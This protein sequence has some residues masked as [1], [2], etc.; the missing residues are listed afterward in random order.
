MK[1]S[2]PTSRQVYF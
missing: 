2:K 1:V